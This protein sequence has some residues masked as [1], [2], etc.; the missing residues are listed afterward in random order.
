[1]PP[2]RKKFIEILEKAMEEGEKMTREEML[3]TYDGVVYPTALCSLEVFK[4]LESF[5]ARSDDVMLA[6]YCKSGEYN[7]FCIKRISMRH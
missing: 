1:M 3:F 6:G 5:E 7:L 2:V 4:A